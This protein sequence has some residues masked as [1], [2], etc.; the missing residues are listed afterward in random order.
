MTA[1]RLPSPLWFAAP[2][3]AVYAAAFVVLE[4]LPRADD[5]GAVAAGLT[6]DLVVLVPALYYAVLVRGRGWPTVTVAPMALVS[7]G[8]ASALVPP[9]HHALLSALGYVLPAVELALVGYVGY[10]AWGVIR[11]KR[12]VDAA[13][14]DVYDRLRETLRDA[15]DVPAVAGALAYEVALLHYAFAVRPAEPP[16]HGVAYHRRGGYGAVVAAV[17]MAAALELVGVHF[18]LRSWS[19]TAA[20]VHL[21]LSLYG[22]VWIV[23]DYRAMRRRPHELRADGLRLRCGLRW[24]V[25]VPWG[26]VLSVRK[27][28]RPAPGDDY[29]STVPVG[30]TG[31]LVE[32]RAPVRATGPYGITR[33]VRRIGLVVDE[34]AAF[35]ERLRECGV[36]VEA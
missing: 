17:L 10:K 32:L 26:A 28:R 14:G 19:E 11:A 20:L 33:D 3:L 34:P 16:E 18:L 5:A 30:D 6:V 12:E 31:Y 21:A 9:E 25:E 35:E 23:G 15:F 27:T 29:L 2:L 7:Y 24:D 36:D 8:A 4:V 13:G 22:V 1:R